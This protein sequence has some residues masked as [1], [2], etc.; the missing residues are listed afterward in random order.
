MKIQ[1]AI[2]AAFGALLIGAAA[3]ASATAV[4]ASG[5]S[6]TTDALLTAGTYTGSFDLSF[7]PQQ[8]RINSAGFSFTFLDDKNDPFTITSG[9]TPPLPTKSGVEYSSKLGMWIITT[10][11]TVLQTSTG[12]LETV[13]LTFNNKT[14]AT[15]ATAATSSTTPDAY[16][17]PS[18]PVV[19]KTQTV[20]VKKNDHTA[21]CT[22]QGNGNACD[23]VPVYDVT[24][25]KTVTTT[26]TDYT[27][28]LQVLDSNL[29]TDAL[30]AEL[31]NNKSLDFSFKVTGDLVF[32]GGTLN[33]DYTDTTPA[34][35]QSV[36][37]P[38]SLALFG[39]ALM[40][41]AGVRR[42]RRG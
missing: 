9:G 39:I 26:T 33:I 37:E 8:Y 6:L 12:E 17:D 2:K 3:Q 16:S 34:P 32:K 22:G 42:A 4:T 19:S 20:K 30:L 7:L 28:S 23:T 13:A 24:V 11:N 21:L 15:V 35:S 36:P 38:A 5:A 27:G 41:V 29:S 1:N 25:T 10:T 40:G 31:A 14:Y 18:T